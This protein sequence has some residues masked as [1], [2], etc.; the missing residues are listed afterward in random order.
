MLQDLTLNLE[1]P[2]TPLPPLNLA[3]TPTEN[4]TPIYHRS[5]EKANKK[6]SRIYTTQAGINTKDKPESKSNDQYSRNEAQSIQNLRRVE[7]KSS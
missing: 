1:A 4:M 6:Y 5:L 3:R 7:V 2:L